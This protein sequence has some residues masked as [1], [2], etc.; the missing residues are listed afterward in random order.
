MSSEPRESQKVTSTETHKAVWT[1]PHIRHIDM[2]RT[3][4]FPAS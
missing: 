4:T 3:L 1:M 2:K